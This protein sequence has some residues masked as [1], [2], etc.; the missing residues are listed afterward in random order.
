MIFL[1]IKLPLE[2]HLQKFI[3]FIFSNI[4][5]E[6]KKIIFFLNSPLLKIFRFFNF[7]SSNSAIVH[8]MYH[9]QYHNAK[10]RCFVF[11]KKRCIIY[12][13]GIYYLAKEK[14]RL[15]LSTCCAYELKSAFESDFN[16]ALRGL[17]FL[18][19]AENNILLLTE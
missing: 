7:F 18:F 6:S 11:K 9:I 12:R 19:V 16:R 8:N 13:Q 10:V 3:I 17:I 5:E 4:V 2:D 1:A 14:K 15:I